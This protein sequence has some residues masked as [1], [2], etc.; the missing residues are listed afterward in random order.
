MFIGREVVCFT[1]KGTL[2]RI[3]ELRQIGKGT[4]GLGRGGKKKTC[5]AVP[6]TLSFWNEGK[7]K[8]SNW[9][10]DQLLEE[11]SVPLNPP[12][13]GK[14]PPNQAGGGEKA[15]RTGISLW[16]KKGGGRAGR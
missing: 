9:S 6:Q 15:R 5:K 4:G 2:R 3:E 1:P 7:K 8:I 13:G 11:K 10:A 12:D 14:S 16:C